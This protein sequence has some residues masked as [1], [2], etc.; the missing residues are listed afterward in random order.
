MLDSRTLS[1]HKLRTSWLGRNNGIG[2]FVL[3]GI[4]IIRNALD[5]DWPDDFSVNLF[6]W[7]LVATTGV[8]MIDRAR[9]WFATK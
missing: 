7:L 9:V 8:S 3:A 2:Y 6:G 4:P 1:G 5:L